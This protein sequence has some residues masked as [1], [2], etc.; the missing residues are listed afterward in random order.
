MVMGRIRMRKR[1]NIMNDKILVVLAVCFLAGLATCRPNCP[2]LIELFKI[3]SS[4]LFGLVTGV[5][6]EKAFKR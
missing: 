4:G 3:L 6:I 5:A 1:R 2:E